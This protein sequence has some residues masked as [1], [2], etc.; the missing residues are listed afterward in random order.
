MGDLVLRIENMLDDSI[1]GV[2]TQAWPKCS[3]RTRKKIGRLLIG[4]APANSESVDVEMFTPP[5][6]RA[7][8]S[9][10]WRGNHKQFHFRSLQTPC[11]I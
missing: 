1:P 6:G 7:V 9:R 5:A 11:I 4:R 8:A 2:L 10:L 3:S